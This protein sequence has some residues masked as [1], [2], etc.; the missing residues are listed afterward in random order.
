MPRR[1]L[2]FV[3]GSFKSKVT[4]TKDL[5]GVLMTKRSRNLDRRICIS[6]IVLQMEKNV[7]PLSIFAEN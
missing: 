4:F 7:D 5:I 6:V 1:K 3:V 2:L